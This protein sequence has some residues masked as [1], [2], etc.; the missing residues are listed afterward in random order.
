MIIIFI[1]MIIIVVVVVVIIVI[2]IVIIILSLLLSLLSSSNEKS[3]DY[4]YGIWLSKVLGIWKGYHRVR[5]IT[6]FMHDT[7]HRR[8]K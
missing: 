7:V 2:I 4:V 8:K 5:K 6:S 3:K 1:I